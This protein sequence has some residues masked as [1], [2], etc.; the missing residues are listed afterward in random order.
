W[1]AAR[2]LGPT[3]ASWPLPAHRLL[4]GTPIVSSDLLPAVWRGDVVV[5][6]AIGR[7][8]GERVRFVDGSEERVDQIVYATG[9][10]IR[11]PF[12][13]S[14]LLAADGRELPL[15]RRIA[16]PGLRRPFLGRLVGAPG[17]AAAG[18]G[19]PGE[20][21]APALPGGARLP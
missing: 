19:A 7:L 14:S 15:Y 6:P 4:E 3:P 11:L 5:K 2:A 13:S 8:S 10:R 1:R 16:P 12:L 18:G 17:G 21:G 9:Y 20:R